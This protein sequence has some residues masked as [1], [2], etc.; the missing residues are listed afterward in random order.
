M[1]P[2]NP[3]P[4]WLTIPKWSATLDPKRGHTACRARV[5]DGSIPEDSLM[6]LTRHQKVAGEYQDITVTYVRE[7]TAYP[8]T[9]WGGYRPGAGRKKA[10]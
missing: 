4:G 9:A 10:V 7:G 6:R 1:A 2:R 8:E 3:P 5:L